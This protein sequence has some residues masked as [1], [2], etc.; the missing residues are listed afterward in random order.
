VWRGACFHQP[1][2]RAVHTARVDGKWKPVTHQLWPLTWSVNSGSGNR[3]RAAPEHRTVCLAR[4]LRPLSPWVGVLLS[5]WCISCAMPVIS[6]ISIQMQ[7]AH[8]TK[9]THHTDAPHTVQTLSWNIGSILF[10][11]FAM[12]GPLAAYFCSFN[13]CSFLTFLTYYLFSLRI[14]FHRPLLFSRRSCVMTRISY[15]HDGRARYICRLF[16]QVLLYK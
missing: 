15:S 14:V 11:C 13:F 4:C 7:F 12:Q 2:W 8:G 1:S 3:G 9:V 5:L 10:L 6:L 16:S